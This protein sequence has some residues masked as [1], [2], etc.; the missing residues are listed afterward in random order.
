M[1]NTFDITTLGDCTIPSPVHGTNFVDTGAILA[2]ATVAGCGL[3]GETPATMERCGPRR[4]IFFDPARARAAVVTCGGLC[5]GLNDVVRALTMVLWHRYGVR[6]VRGLRYGY[7]GLIPR[8]GH[9]VLPLTPEGVD[10]IH[11]NGGTILGT[12]RG[13]QDVPEQVD[14]LQAEGINLLFPI[15]GDGTQRGALDITREAQA[16]G[17]P[18]AVVGIPK[19][20]DNDISF[21]DRTFGYETAV[22]QSRAPITGIH[23]EAKSIHNGVGL[24]KLMGRH[25]GFIAASAALASSDVNLV[26]IPEVPFRE[27]QLMEWLDARLAVKSHAVIVVAEGAGQELVSTAGT[28]KS[29][30][31]NLGD[32]GLYLKHAIG[33]HLVDRGLDGGVKYIDPSYSIRSAPASADDSVFCFQLGANAVHA[34]MSGR[35]GLVVSQW[36]GHFVHV[37]IEQAVAQRKCVDPGGPLWTSVLDNTGQP[38]SD[39]LKATGLNER[40]YGATP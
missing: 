11:H 33:K 7:E 1:A 3:D 5:P 39:T 12:S 6:D 14:Y 22:E 29:G 31:R 16:R 17:Y 32:I 13:P 30:N 8:Y 26:L 15:G 21:T 9:P 20:I 37:P 27:A 24:V 40:C 23:H 25:S 35:T 2:D 18:L 19:T 36:N 34:A 38:F 28:D 10:D 4:A